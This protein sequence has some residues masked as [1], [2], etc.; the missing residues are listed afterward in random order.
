MLQIQRAS[1]GSGK[2]YTLAKKFIWFLIAIKNPERPWRLRSHREIADGL[3]RILAITFTNKATNEMKLRIVDNLAAM[4]VAA[5]KNAVT[6]LLLKQ[7]PYLKEFADELSVSPSKVGEAAAYALSVLLN[8]Y[9]DFRISTIDSFFQSV[10]RTFAYESNLN[11]SY[12]VEIDTDYLIMASI[13]ATLNEL[14]RP[15]TDDTTA[16]KWI[17]ILTREAAENGGKWNVFQK[18]ANNNSVYSSLRKSLKMMESEEFKEIRTSL[19]NYFLNNSETL[20]LE[21]VYT[22]LKKQVETPVIEALETAR[23]LGN[24]LQTRLKKAGIDPGADCLRNF[25]GH[26]SKLKILTPEVSPSDKNIFAPLKLAGKSLLK[27]GVSHPEAQ[28]FTDLALQ[29]YEAYTQWLDLRGRQEWLYWQVYAPLLPYLGLLGEARLKMTEFLEN[30][31]LI[32]LGET[33]SMLQDI[34]GE[35]DAPFIYE[36][37]GSVINHFLIDE[38]QDTSRM[39]WDNLHPL[40]KESDSRG[41]DNL[42]I[43]DAK[44][45][46][47]RFRNADP[48]LITTVVPSLF[49]SH[50]SAGMTRAENTNWRSRRRIVEFNNLF[51]SHLAQYVDS[52]KLGELDFKDLYANVAQYSNHRDESGYVEVRIMSAELSDEEK[53]AGKTVANVIEENILKEIGPLITSLRRRG[54]AQKDIAILTDTN[55]EGKKIIAALVEYNETLPAGTPSIDFISEE[56]LLVSQSEAVG[57]LVAILRYLATGADMDLSFFSLR[58]PEQSAA[59]HITNYMT[60]ESPRKEV[61]EI[62]NDMQARTLTGIVEAMTEKFVPEAMRREQAVYLA[63]FQDMVIDYTDRYPADAASFLDWWDSKGQFRSISSP[64]GTDAVSIMTIHKSKGLE[65]GCVILPFADSSLEPSPSQSEWRWVKPSSIFS[66]AGLPPFVPVK[67]ERKLLET[68][69]APV[70]V[71][72]HDL[73]MMDKLNSAYVAFTRAV[74]ELYIFTRETKNKKSLGPMLRQILTPTEDGDLNL[75]FSIGEEESLLLPSECVEWDEEKTIVKI[76][77]KPTYCPTD[78]ESGKK[79]GGKVEERTLGAYNVDSTPAILHIVETDDT[80]QTVPDPD[81]DPRSEGNLLHAIMERVKKA[82]DL[83]SAV[84]TLRMRGMVSLEQAQ[85]WEPMLEEAMKGEE[86]AGWFDGSWRVANEREI[87]LPRMKNRR[88]DRLM[89]NADRS[90][91]IVVDYKFGV[92]PEGD[93]HIE[94]VREYVELIRLAVRPRYIEGY[95]WYVREGKIIRV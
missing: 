42:I 76:G 36:R 52:W 3:A 53:A 54:V 63:A 80:S 9:S 51:F 18:N 91:A 74:D 7:T 69:H 43:G 95:I 56:A 44:Q 94:Q 49:P 60:A 77:E 87:I 1:A 82:D 84:L 92:I 81:D 38:F 86:V 70:Y 22:A 75:D 61:D 31:N 73:F 41:E 88:P 58:H 2:T 26:L 15:G 5:D 62:I 67:T 21:D 34:I 46:I 45:S 66:E 4:A 32:Q 71:A 68:E 47:Y 20:P 79:R 17:R 85:E 14:N 50:K 48:S 28:V 19:D 24:Q 55:E 37:L 93:E 83:H 11:D 10:L 23:R 35:D 57:I 78:T 33:N 59:G 12:Q 30:N 8:E 16:G 65:F 89:F 25:S 40:L 39:Q 29:M 13:E 90:R 72:Y 27:K 64:E 6:P